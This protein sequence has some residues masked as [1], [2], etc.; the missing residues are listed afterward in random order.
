MENDNI[1]VTIVT[2]SYNQGGFIGATI[3]SVL[4]QTY[5]NIEYIIVDGESTDNT[6]DVIANYNDRIDTIIHERDKGQSDAINKGFKLAK[7]K[8]VGWLNSDD[9]IEPNCVETIVELYKNN[10]DGAIFYGSKINV[11]DRDSNIIRVSERLIP[12]RDHLLRQNYDVIQQG[13]FYRLDIVKKI[14]YLNEDIYYCM[15]LD[16]SLRLLE[17]GGIYSYNKQPLASFRLWEETKTMNGEIKFLNN[18]RETL[19][20]YGA[21]PTDNTILKC[22]KETRRFKF[23]NLVYKVFPFVKPLRKMLKGKK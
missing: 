18:I 16:L 1:L 7:G 8:L 23:R 3:E 11:I 14:D 22:A 15:D 10:P 2:P 19:I 9:T 4:S 6:M 20:K 17:H 12:T 5:N 21:K 13:S